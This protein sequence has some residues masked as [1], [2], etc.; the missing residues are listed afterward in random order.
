M[1]SW[2]VE[3]LDVLDP[4]AW[5]TALHA[6]RLRRL[7]SGFSAPWLS[8]RGISSPSLRAPGIAA[9]CPI[10]APGRAPTRISRFGLSLDPAR[11]GG[12]APCWI[13]PRHIRFWEALAGHE[14]G[15]S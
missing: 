6:E 1:P 15:V 2:L 8:S 13:R 12:P 5:R 3:R 11:A 10:P 4:I 14:T 9:P 7:S